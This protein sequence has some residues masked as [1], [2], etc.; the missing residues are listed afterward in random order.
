MSSKV[1]KLG[2]LADIFQTEKLDG[3]IRK[4]KLSHIKPAEFQPR[5][6]RQKGVE[7]LAASLQ[8]EGLLQPIVVSK[9]ETSN[10]YTIIAG[11]R[12]Y[13]AATSLGWKEIECKILDKN[14][15]ESYRIAVIENLQR[16]QLSP[17][18]EV[19]AMFLLKSRYGYTDLQLGQLFHKSRNYMSELL[20]ISRLSEAE[21]LACKEA[22]IQNKNFLVQAVQAAKNQDLQKFLKAFTSGKITTVKAAKSFN[23]QPTN[24]IPTNKPKSPTTELEITQKKGSLVVKSKDQQLLQQI[25]KLLQEKF[26]T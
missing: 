16:E 15:K 20:S 26:N 13:H 8:A 7:D 1:K 3:S 10:S 19:E 2:N 22:G 11:E 21:L 17:Y 23:K 24:P 14:E 12:R 4:I 5:K 6:M 9:A 25:Y 18:E